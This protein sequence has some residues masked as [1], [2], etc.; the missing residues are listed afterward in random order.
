[1][2]HYLLMPRRKRCWARLAERLDELTPELRKA[3]AYVLEHPNDVGV[4]SIREIA[5]AALVKPNSFMRMARAVGFE[6]YDELS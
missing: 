6:G 1:M 4:S 2:Y 5:D 3:A